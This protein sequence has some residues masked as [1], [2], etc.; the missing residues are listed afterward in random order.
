MIAP[1][2][3]PALLAKQA[4]GLDQI[5]GGR[6]TLG[7]ATGWRDG[8]FTVAGRDYSGRGRRLD[9]DIEF[10][11]RAW[12]GELVDGA[13]KKLTPTP[14]NGVSVPL[15]FG[16]NAPAAFRTRCGW[17]RQGYRVPE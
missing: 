8:D 12:R 3:A 16:G 1:A 9:D 7:V 17:P 10:T 2:Y 6:F 5:S 4:A 11:Q 13:T 15:A 14:T